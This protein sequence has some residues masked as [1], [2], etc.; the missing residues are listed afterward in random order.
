MH[1]H[2]HIYVHK[3][4]H[5]YIYI[6]IYKLTNREYYR[7]QNSGTKQRHLDTYYFGKIY[8]GFNFMN[9]FY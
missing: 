4:M 8:F 5:I 7:L 9:A 2:A 1:V 3:N 6:Y